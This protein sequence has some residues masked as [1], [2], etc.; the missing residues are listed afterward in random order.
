MIGQIRKEVADKMKGKEKELNLKM[1][2]IEEQMKKK[3]GTRKSVR[4]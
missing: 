1:N 3:A 2:E 4:A